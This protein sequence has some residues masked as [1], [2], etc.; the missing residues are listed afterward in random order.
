M[1]KSD[2]NKDTASRLDFFLEDANLFSLWVYTN[3]NFI[4]VEDYFR[5]STIT[6]LALWHYKR[7]FNF[8]VYKLNSFK[9][10]LPKFKTFSDV[11][12]D[13]L[14]VPV[15]EAAGASLEHLQKIT[16]IKER[17]LGGMATAEIW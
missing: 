10:P 3:P 2:K 15:K 11:P 9:I 1:K 14:K 12:E 6:P 5:M 17:F 13:E 8:L 4:P 7:V 16:T